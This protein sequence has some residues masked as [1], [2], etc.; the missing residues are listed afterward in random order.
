[1]AREADVDFC[2]IHNLVEPEKAGVERRFGIKVSLPAGDTFG[3]LLGDDWERVHWY[4]TEQD[5]DQ[6]REEHLEHVEDGSDQPV[7]H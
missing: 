4:A 5:R 3:A 7:V 1:M 2:H 6:D